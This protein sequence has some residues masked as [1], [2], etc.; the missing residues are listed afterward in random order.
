[1]PVSLRLKVYQKVTCQPVCLSATMTAI[2]QDKKKDADA[3]STSLFVESNISIFLE[4]SCKI[5][6]CKTFP[7]KILIN[8]R[9]NTTVTEH[10]YQKTVGNTSV[11]NVSARNTT[12]QCSHTA[13]N[14]WNHTA[15]NNSSSFKRT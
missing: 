4:K 11:N 14:F 15:C 6:P 10:F 12:F 2:Q 5:I 7:D 13:V 8:H 1:M 3:R 9:T